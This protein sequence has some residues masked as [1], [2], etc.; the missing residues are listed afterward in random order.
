[1][2]QLPLRIGQVFRV[3]SHD[4]GGAIVQGDGATV[5]QAINASASNLDLQT[6]VI[7]RRVGIHEFDLILDNERIA[8]LSLSFVIAPISQLRP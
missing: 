8:S 3:A 1:M 6:I 4:P 5:D 7:F 2:P